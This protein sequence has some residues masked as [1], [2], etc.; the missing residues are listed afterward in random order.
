LSDVLHPDE[1]VGV[2]GNGTDVP[3][4]FDEGTKEV[5]RTKAFEARPVSRLIFVAIIVAAKFR[6]MSVGQTAI[7]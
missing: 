7:D 5:D 6:L 2:A 4:V 1:N 3:E